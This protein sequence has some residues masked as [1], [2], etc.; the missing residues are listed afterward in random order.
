VE[1]SRISLGAG[2]V[3]V[4][5]V[6][7]GKEK[8]FGERLASLGIL[9][10]TWVFFQLRHCSAF[11]DLDSLLPCVLHLEKYL[12]PFCNE[13]PGQ[14]LRMNGARLRFFS[15]VPGR[16][17]VPGISKLHPGW[18]RSGHSKKKR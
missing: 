8:N 13:P 12:A 3:S 11:P 16:D 4:E 1:L 5:V 6:K 15:P 9:V 14:N 10:E 7:N 2:V 18:W 17:Q